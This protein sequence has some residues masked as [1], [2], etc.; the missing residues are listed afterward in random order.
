MRTQ[1]PNDHFFLN[2]GNDIFMQALYCFCLF[3]SQNTVLLR[4]RFHPRKAKLRRKRCV[5][6]NVEVKIS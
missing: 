4:R 5:L 2:D 1:G 6:P 3:T